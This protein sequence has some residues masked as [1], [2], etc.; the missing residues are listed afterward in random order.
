MTRCL[1]ILLQF[2]KASLMQAM[3]YRA[4]FFLG[5]LANAFD[6]GFGLVQYSLFFLVAESVAGWEMPQLLTF[7]AV[8]MTVLSLHLIF[9]YPNL[10]GIS[11]LVNSGKLDL[12]LTKPNSPQVLLSFRLLSFEELGSFTAAQCL[13]WGLVL[14]GAISV[15]GGQ[16]LAFGFALVCCFRL[17]YSVF[18][19]FLALAVWFEKLENMSDL[20]WSMFGLCRY[21]VDVFPGWLRLVFWNIIPIA[22][23]T[24]VP[25]RALLAP[26][27]FVAAGQGRGAGAHLFPGRERFLAPH[28]AHLLLGGGLAP[29]LPARPVA[30]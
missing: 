25:A 13:L 6:F 16:L 12:V 3:E 1:R 21:P 14:T 7:Y 29:A 28:P 20:L 24:T 8:F 15:T 19:M 27:R 23:V 17:V 18:V 9:L 30:T 22:F 11:T 2:W 26:P 4:S 5:I 10:D